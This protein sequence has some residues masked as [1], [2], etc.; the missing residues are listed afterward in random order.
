LPDRDGYIAGVPCWVDTSQPDRGAA[1]EFY[2]GLFGWE[3][4]DAMPAGPPGRYLVARLR[5]GDVAAVSSQPGER[6]CRRSGIPTS[7][8]RT[9]TRM[10]LPKWPTKTSAFPS[11]PTPI[12]TT[13]RSTRKAFSPEI[14]GKNEN[15]LDA[16]LAEAGDQG[17]GDRRDA[18]RAT[19]SRGR[20]LRGRGAR[21]L[22]RGA[23]RRSARGE[24]GEG[25]GRRCPAEGDRQGAGAD[26]GN[27]RRRRRLPAR[28]HL[29]AGLR[30]KDPLSEL[31]PREREVLELIAEGRLP[32]PLVRLP[33]PKDTSWPHFR[34]ALPLPGS[35]HQP[36]APKGSPCLSS[37]IPS[38]ARPDSA[39]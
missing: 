34:S 4:G 15:Y 39:R 35:E 10:W 21:P 23:D 1:A 28:A 22:V 7:G 29:P 26:R 33:A 19:A 31:T 11:G 2:G 20:P 5:G 3:F 24:A 12:E 13:D 18:L 36:T 25:Q 27:R 32:A 8:S 17:P 37:T 6:P 9:A 38:S 16:L 30:G 14:N